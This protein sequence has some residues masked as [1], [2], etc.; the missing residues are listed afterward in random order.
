MSDPGASPPA[1]AAMRL[2]IHADDV[3]MNH[4]ANRAFVELS[5]LGTVTA[6]S[7]MVPCPWFSEIAEEA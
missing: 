1:P 3:G 2:V 7:V 6:G 5:R 4:G